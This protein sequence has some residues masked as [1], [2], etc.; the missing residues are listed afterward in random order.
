DARHSDLLYGLPMTTYEAYNEY[1][2]KSLYDFNSSGATTISG[3]AKAVKVSFDRP[4]EQPRVTAYSPHDWY[5]VSDYP[6]VSW[7][8]RMGYDVAYQSVTDLERSGTRALD[9][10]A[11]VMPPHDEYYSANMRASLV[12]ARDG[13]KSILVSGSNALYWKIRFENGPNGGQDRI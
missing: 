6:L 11:Y 13:G 2:G 5:P 7:L 10:K 8:E 4:F 9:H 1:G 3:T 12:A